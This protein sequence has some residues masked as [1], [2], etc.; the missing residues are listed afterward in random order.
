VSQAEGKEFP[1]LSARLDT[2]HLTI[3]PQYDYD[4]SQPATELSVSASAAPPNE[5][6]PTIA[7]V[8]SGD[9]N[10]DCYDTQ[11]DIKT[12][13]KTAP[14]GY[15]VE[16]VEDVGAAEVSAG[17]SAD[18]VISGDRRSVTLTGKASG[19]ACFRNGVGDAANT[20]AIVE[21]GSSAGGPLG[22]LIGGI[23][24]A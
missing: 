16:S 18:Y 12:D 6:D 24:A 21:I 20:A 13:S 15:V 14:T 5:L 10:Y 4:R 8:A 11:P 7:K 9:V 22:T 2:G 1:C 17:S 23:A 19:H 3:L